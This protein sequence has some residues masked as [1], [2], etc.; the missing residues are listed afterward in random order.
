MG[1]FQIGQVHKIAFASRRPLVAG[2]ETVGL[3]DNS[4]V[5]AV[6]SCP[7]AED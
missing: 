7:T 1:R 5:E 4:A 3:D 2:K 6:E